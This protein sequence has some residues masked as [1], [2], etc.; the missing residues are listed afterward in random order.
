[1]KFDRSLLHYLNKKIINS[2]NRLFS[3]TYYFFELCHC[4]CR[5][6]KKRLCKILNYKNN[7]F[8]SEVSKVK[9][10]FFPVIVMFILQEAKVIL[11][12]LFT[13][14]PWI[15]STQRLIKKNKNVNDQ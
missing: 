9:V 8:I 15:E 3:N 6:A 4:F 13:Q 11:T 12:L 1:M 2:L 5:G 14:T 10:S 7:F